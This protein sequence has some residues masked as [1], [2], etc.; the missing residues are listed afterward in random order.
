MKTIVALA[1]AL[2]LLTGA[3]P[4]KSVGIED[5]LGGVRYLFVSEVDG[6]VWGI[7]CPGSLRD[8]AFQTPDQVRHCGFTRS[9]GPVDPQRLIDRAPAGV[10]R[11][12]LEQDLHGLALVPV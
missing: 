10:D 3:A 7:V 4:T 8:Y 5:P 9:I 11:Y 2:F 6:N 1:F 12:R